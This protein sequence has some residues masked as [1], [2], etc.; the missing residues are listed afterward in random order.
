ML[1]CVY[2]PSTPEFKLLEAVHKEACSEFVLKKELL[3]LFALTWDPSG[4]TALTYKAIFSDLSIYRG[5]MV[6][7]VPLGPG[8]LSFLNGGWKVGTWKGV[9]IK[10]CQPF[11]EFDP[12]SKITKIWKPRNKKKY[13]EE[14]LMPDGSMVVTEAEIPNLH[15]DHKGIRTRIPQFTFPKEGFTKVY[16]HYTGTSYSA[17]WKKWSNNSKRTPVD[18]VYAD[19]MEFK[20]I[21][22]QHNYQNQT[23]ICTSGRFRFVDGSGF[24]G[25]FVN[26]TIG[27]LPRSIKKG[28]K[29]IH[30]SPPL[31][32]SKCDY[33]S[34]YSYFEVQFEFKN[35]S[36]FKGKLSSSGT[37]IGVITN[38]DG[39]KF[40]GSLKTHDSGVYYPDDG[41]GTFYSISSTQNFIKRTGSFTTEEIFTFFCPTLRFIF[42]G[43]EFNFNGDVVQYLKTEG[44]INQWLKI[45]YSNG[46]HFDGLVEN[47]Y[48][49][50][51]QAKPV[52]GTGTWKDFMTGTIFRGVWDEECSNDIEVIYPDGSTYTGAVQGITILPYKRLDTTKHSTYDFKKN[53][54]SC[55][56][57]DRGYL[58]NQSPTC[59]VITNHCTRKVTISRERFTL[60]NTSG[61]FSSSCLQMLLS[62]SLSSTFSPP[63][64]GDWEVSNSSSSTSREEGIKGKTTMGVLFFGH[65]S[66]WA[67]RDTVL[68]FGKGKLAFGNSETPIEYTG[69]SGRWIR[70]GDAGNLQFGVGLG[71]G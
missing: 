45:K 30:T 5:V 2:S 28:S 13:Q 18:V 23:L 36:V 53:V 25:E 9:S 21:L 3:K 47:R 64:N 40:S 8:R 27:S 57:W 56:H 59:S 67:Q 60:T 49:K 41:I 48:D 19:G 26:S 50:I 63:G 70:I 71:S 65:V 34:K 66:Q 33:N 68:F 29:Y 10:T 15:I 7:G 62:K 16:C 61:L 20:G 32:F 52:R 17:D 58:V 44:T 39:S 22:R 24:D 31:I 43:V 54:G 46:D 38:N 1:D 11:R 42:V 37:L 6:G 55:I 14:F 4:T 35:S 51:Y 69:N 12:H